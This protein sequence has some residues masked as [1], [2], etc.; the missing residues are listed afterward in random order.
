MSA[1]SIYTPEGTFAYMLVVL[2][3]ALVAA[4]VYLFAFAGATLPF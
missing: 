2:G 4:V 1:P 3:L